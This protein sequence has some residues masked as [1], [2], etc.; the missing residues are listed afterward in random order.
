L[1]PPV[2]HDQPLDPVTIGP[3]A[4]RTE[5]GAAEQQL[6]FAMR[7][8]RRTQTHGGTQ[9]GGIS[10]G[11]RTPHSRTPVFLSLSLSLSQMLFLKFEWLVCF[12]AFTG[13][14]LFLCTD[15][16]FFFFF[17]FFW[18]SFALVTL[19]A[20]TGGW[21][22]RWVMCAHVLTCL[23]LFFFFLLNYFLYFDRIYCDLCEFCSVCICEYLFYI[24][25]RL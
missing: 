7:K 20:F 12:N 19:M 15:G 18:I 17:F 11:T 22:Q 1:K 13:S 24:Y 4:Q 16:F 21:G 9:T 2:H 3:P 5:G 14:V 10:H 6:A 25:L 23:F 8:A